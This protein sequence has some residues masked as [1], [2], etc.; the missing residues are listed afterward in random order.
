MSELTIARHEIG[1]A[2]VIAPAGRIDSST[3]AQFQETVI[4]AVEGGATRMVLDFSDVGYIS[5]AG[6][7]VVLLAG[8]R[9]K[10]GGGTLALCGMQPSI[11]E[12]FEISGFI[13]LFEVR[14][15]AQDA[16]DAI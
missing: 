7:R 2:S 8:K 14:D 6:L 16:A 9:L 10:G 5:S 12:V 4:E 11:R 13:G 15:T 1:G 3:A